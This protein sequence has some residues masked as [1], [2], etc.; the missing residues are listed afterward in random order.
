M[1]RATKRWT[2]LGLLAAAGAGLLLAACGGGTTAQIGPTAALLAP[3]YLSSSTDEVGFIQW[4]TQGSSVSG[5]YNRVYTTGGVPNQTTQTVQGT[6]GG[7]VN[8]SR[9]SVNISGQGPDFGNL[10]GGALTINFPQRDGTLRALS[11]RPATAD[12]YNRAVLGLQDQ[13]A[14]ANS[15]E[16]QRERA[17]AAQAAQQQPTTTFPT[18]PTTTPQ[19]TVPGPSGRLYRVVQGVV[20]RDSASGSGNALGSIPTGS[21]VGVLCKVVGET[22]TG[23]YGPD[24]SWDRVTVN[25]VSG[26][27]TDEWIDTEQDEF[28]ASKVPSC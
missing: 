7:T 11:F 17:A 14:S 26:Y 9:V 16:V 12:D 10:G 21:M 23:P 18:T 27:V 6:A 15:A 22:I 24:S 25:G 3:G 2:G 5:S 20:I 8:G 13:V 1:D 19:G 28:D 4:T